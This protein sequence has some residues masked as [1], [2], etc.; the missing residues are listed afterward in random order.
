MNNVSIVGRFTRDL[1]L[2]YSKEGK[3][4]LKSSVAVNRPTPPPTTT[5]VSTMTGVQSITF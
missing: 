5:G 2:K 3:A 4:M 1:T